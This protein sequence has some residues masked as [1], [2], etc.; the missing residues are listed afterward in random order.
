MVIEANAG[1]GDPCWR[2]RVP[3]L[4][5]E[6][7][8]SECD[9]FFPVPSLRCLTLVS[10]WTLLGG[11]DTAME[12]ESLLLPPPGQEPLLAETE[13]LINKAFERL[14]CNV[15]M[16]Q[17]RIHR[18]PQ[19]LRG[20]GGK[21]NRY[22][23]PCV[24]AIGPY[25]NGRPH[26][27]EMEEVKQ[28]AA[29]SFCNA[30]GRSFKEVYQKVFSVAGDA[31]R[32]YDA[33]SV[34]HLSDAAL[35]TMMF[36]DGCFLMQLMTKPEDPPIVG[37]I[38][39]HGP[40]ILKDVF[41]LEN[42]IPWL[43]LEA[44]MELRPVRVREWIFAQ[45]PGLCIFQRNERIV[46]SGAMRFLKKCRGITEEK[47]FGEDDESSS[48]SQGDSK[49]PHLLGVLRFI[50]ICNMRPEKRDG[51]T[52][53]FSAGSLRPL[54]S[55]SAVYLSQIGVKLTVSTARWFADMDVRKRKPF[56]GE[57]S[58]SPLFLNDLTACCLVNLVGLEAAEAI[59]AS[60]IR[61]DGFVVSSY[62]SMFAMLMDREED[63]QHL[64]G[65]GVLSS[66]FCDKQ[67]LNFFKDL[68][69]H[70]RPGFNYF[71]TMEEIDKYMRER[72][73]RIAVH[74]FLYNHYKSTSL[75]SPSCQLPVCSSASLRNFI[76][77]RPRGSPCH[78]Q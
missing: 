26:L 47:T 55:S 20:I 14:V 76:Q 16:T 38:L 51:V 36:L 67:T 18:F 42:Q 3:I 50:M 9:Y 10:P 30:P 64:R 56:F 60:S 32:C 43:V 5:A 70:L 69:R 35:A 27:Q 11:S 8:L 25:H 41:L 15:S 12:P 65:K 58:L 53:R 71:A 49:P 23:E 13:E 62:V 21:E 40:R 2:L 54:L 29:Y 78:Q 19:H 73:G 52:C 75:S 48:I 77:L 31:R 37:R 1:A 68:G 7:P 44:L 17:R 22:T 66:R 63:V 39:S 24:V 59:D 46:R 74:K 28:A 6:D 72:P 57:L 4:R 45:M 61:S 33:S 34:A